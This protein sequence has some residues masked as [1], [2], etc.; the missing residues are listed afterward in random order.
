MKL[1]FCVA[2][3]TKR[4][5]VHALLVP[6]SRGG[7]YVPSNTVTLCRACYALSIGYRTARAREGRAAAVAKGIRFGRPSKLRVD[8]V[9]TIMARRAKGERLAGLAREY[10]MSISSISRLPRTRAAA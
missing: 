4:R 3:G 8:Q 9:L 7:E 1:S 2:C 6:T 10:N 5:L